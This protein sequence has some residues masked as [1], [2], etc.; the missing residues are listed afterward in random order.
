[1]E[2]PITILFSPA[3]SA[4]SDVDADGGVTITSSDSTQV[5][6]G[7]LGIAGSGSVTSSVPAGTSTINTYVQASGSFGGSPITIKAS[8]PGYTAGS[9]TVTIANTGFVVSGPG[10]SSGNISTFEGQT[11]ALTV[12]PYQL[13]SSSNPVLNANEVVR[14]GYTMNVPVSS[15]ATS[16]GTVCI[17]TVVFGT[18]TCTPQSTVTVPITGPAASGSLNFV[19]STSNTGAVTVT[20]GPL[21]GFATPATGSTVTFNVQPTDLVLPSSL[22]VG[23]NLQSGMTISRNGE[24]S[25][26]A[27]VTITSGNSSLLLFSTTPQGNAAGGTCTVAPCPATQSITV[28]VPVNQTV[29]PTFYAHA[30]GG[31][32]T[33]QYTVFATGYGTYT[34]TITLAPS[35]LIMV[36]PP[37]PPGASTFELSLGSSGNV[38]I[39]TAAFGGG[40]PTPQAV[41]YGVTVSAAVSSG[42]TAIGTISGSPV[43]ITAGLGTDSTTYA[44]FLGVGLGSTSINATSTG[45]LSASTNVTVVN[46]GKLIVGDNSGGTSVGNISGTIGQ[47]LEA[48]GTVTVPGGAPTSDVQIQLTSN[49]SSTLWLSTD[50]V[51]WSS[52]VTVTVAAGSQSASANYYIQAKA[53]AGTASYTASAAS[54]GYGAATET[55]NEMPSGIV[56]LSSSDSSSFSTSLSAGPQLFNVFTAYLS[57]DGLNTPLNP[58]ALALTS[59]TVT[60]GSTAPSVGTAASVTINAGSEGGLIGTFTP[61][62]GSSQGLSTGISVN[63]PSGWTVPGSLT[64]LG[65]TVTTP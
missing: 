16:V 22:T 8:L 51:N 31:S 36:T 6:L 57:S 1:M 49:N 48:Q 27:Q 26:V 58:Q 5:L 13:D 30:Y 53:S 15:S 62:S 63:T 20:A 29:T 52:T 39:N 37:P 11:T 46:L 19:A 47:F 54:Y 65:V 41:A 9:G 42:N 3:L 45:Y 7:S 4:D 35:G 50:N 2:V 43:T 25:T 40:S 14:P 64:T 18:T 17:P 10:E 32:G 61:L 33:V 38:V 34:G 59:L 28:T 60:F 12:T 55:I 21:A 56:I 24:T 44:S 23:N